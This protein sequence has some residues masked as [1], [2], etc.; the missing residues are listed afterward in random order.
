MRIG[1]HFQYSP[2]HP[3]TMDGFMYGMMYGNPY[4]WAFPWMIVA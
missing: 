1:E 3:C 4:G 2:W